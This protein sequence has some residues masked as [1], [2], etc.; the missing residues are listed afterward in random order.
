MIHVTCLLHQSSYEIRICMKQIKRVILNVQ[1]CLQ[2]VGLL[3]ARTLT[4]VQ[5]WKC[6]SVCHDIVHTETKLI[7]DITETGE[8]QK[9]TV[10]SASVSFGIKVRS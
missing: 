4:Q 10:I 6:L 9:V 3:M 1:I 7:S 5:A 8:D 2:K